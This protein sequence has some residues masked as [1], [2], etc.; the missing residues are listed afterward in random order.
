MPLGAIILSLAG[1]S[2][3]ALAFL[4]TVKAP[5]KKPTPRL[6]EIGIATVGMLCVMLAGVV[7]YVD[8]Q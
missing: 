2:L 8:E 3:G 1:I 7:I 6:M 4:R 5:A